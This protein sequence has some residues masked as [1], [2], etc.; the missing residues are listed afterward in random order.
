[1]NSSY[2]HIYVYYRRFGEKGIMLRKD[3]PNPGTGEHGKIN[4]TNKK[5]IKRVKRL[6]CLLMTGYLLAATLPFVEHKPVQKEVKAAF[7]PMKCYGNE[8]GWERAYYIHDN[9]EALIWR[10]RMIDQAEEKIILTT[11]EI[12]ADESGK[13]IMAALLEA[14][15]RGVNVE[16]LTNGIN[17]FLHI[18]GDA[19]FAA[20]FSHEKISL[21]VYNPVDFLRPWKL[22]SGFHDKYILVDEKMYLLGGRN[23]NDLFLGE[24]IS[25]QNTDGDV[26]VINMDDSG[27]NPGS[28]HELQAYYESVKAEPEV[29]LRTAGRRQDKSRPGQIKDGYE[30]LT[31]RR[32]L[33][34]ERY[35]QAYEPFDFE[36]N[37][38]PARKITLLANPVYVGNKEPELWYY[39]NQLALTGNRVR[40]LTPYII[41]GKDM[42]HDLAALCAGSDA[43]DIITNDVRN[44][45]NPFGC[46]D[47]LNE[48]KRVR[49]TGV[50]V[51]EYSGP[52]SLHTKTI[53]V[54]ERLSIIGSFNLDMRSTYIHTEVMVAIDS[55]EL[56]A[57]VQ[58]VMDDLE[59]YC[60]SADESGSYTQNAY[61]QDKPISPAKTVFYA[62]LR[63]LVKL[64]RRFL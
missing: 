64:F 32:T 3:K 40:I 48:K 61:Y 58:Q 50:K 30:E 56:N 54:D 2:L 1:M 62:V 29:F 13:D 4:K 28:I 53:T 5:K 59:L 26:F 16:I 37:T 39:L 23:T 25:E 35:K 31:A 44:G 41:C 24:Y 36:A 45:A 22:Q 10:L 17:E 6:I 60:R 33:V 49:K 47:Y 55:P 34:R 7:N 8:P 52:Y 63:V 18:R 27:T 12:R 42:Y 46:T 51:H 43:V 21:Y 14:A 19:D 38:Y 9:L 11:F 20:F 15:D 57:A